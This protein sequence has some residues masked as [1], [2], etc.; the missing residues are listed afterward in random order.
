MSAERTALVP[1][2]KLNGPADV[3]SWANQAVAAVEQIS[4]QSRDSALSLDRRAAVLEVG[5]ARFGE[6][7]VSTTLD[8]DT[9]S[10]QYF[11]YS[12]TT[13]LTIILPPFERCPGRVIGFKKMSVPNSV[14]IRVGSGLVEGIAT[15]TMTTH[16]EAR[17][18]QCDGRIGWWII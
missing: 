3:V 17:T 9:L 14:I 18:L 15:L 12:D 10:T 2:P 4:K 8:A 1:V 7:F 6:I 5:D 13:S 16:R 11:V